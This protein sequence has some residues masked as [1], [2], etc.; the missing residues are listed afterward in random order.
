MKRNHIPPE[1]TYSPS[2]IARRNEYIDSL[3]AGIQPFAHAAFE[4]AVRRQTSEESATVLAEEARSALLEVLAEPGAVVLDEETMRL[5]HD[6][7]AALEQNVETPLKPFDTAWIK[8]RS[9]DLARAIVGFWVGL[10]GGEMAR[11][12]ASIRIL[13]H[14]LTGKES[15]PRRRFDLVCSRFRLDASEAGDLLKRLNVVA[16]VRQLVKTATSTT[17]RAT[18]EMFWNEIPRVP[19]AEI[20]KAVKRNPGRSVEPLVPIDRSAPSYEPVMHFLKAVHDVHREQYVR[21]EEGNAAFRAQ[22]MAAYCNHTALVQGAIGA[23]AALFTKH[24][25]S[26]SIQSASTRRAER[27][28]PQ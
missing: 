22:R 8:R 1:N 6:L 27:A 26:I 10:G 20:V 17:E 19:P 13:D 5:K 2:D 21:I 14:M 16:L 25:Q 4:S 28:A 23:A 24:F 18:V 3:C 7:A 11:Y 9:K 15:E 12:V